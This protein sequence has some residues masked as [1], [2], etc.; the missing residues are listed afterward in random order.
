VTRLVVDA[1]ALVEYLF[2]L[3]ARFD[4]L[5]THGD[6]HIPALADIEFA[7]GAV[8]LLARG[9]S[10]E[11]AVL[12][13]LE[14]LASLSLTRHGHSALLTRVLTLRH[15]FSVYDATYVALAESLDAVLLTADLKLAAAVATHTRVRVTSSATRS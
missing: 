2:R 12:V 14:D 11:R 3:S 13:A 6:L 9:L 10:D 8:R 1:S 4:D 5:I 7:S 15:N